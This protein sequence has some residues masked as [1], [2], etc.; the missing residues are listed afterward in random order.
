[1]DLGWWVVYW[2]GN[3]VDFGGGVWI[4]LLYKDPGKLRIF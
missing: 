2:T 3:G 4:Y 1:M